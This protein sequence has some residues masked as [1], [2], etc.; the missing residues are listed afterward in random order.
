MNLKVPMNLCQM[1]TS[2]TLVIEPC[3]Y[4]SVAVGVG[5]MSMGIMTA[6]VL[7]TE[8]IPVVTDALACTELGGWMRW[9][10]R[11]PRKY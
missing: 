8:T 5:S 2:S 4:F 7:A 3:R 1:D 10:A 9:T 11:F 6:T